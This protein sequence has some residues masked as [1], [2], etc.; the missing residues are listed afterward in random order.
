ME[1]ASLKP[2]YL[3]SLM[4]QDYNYSSVKTP[5]GLTARTLDDASD[6]FDNQFIRANDGVLV[7]VGDLSA[8]SVQKILCQY[9]GGFRVSK[10]S[11]VRQF[12][13]YKLRTGATTYSRIGAPVEI[14]LALACAEP[15]TT[16]NYMAFKV[17]S[18]ALQRRLTGV[19]AE[20]GF[21][22]RMADRFS[23]WPQEA[24]E[25]IFTCTPVPESGLPYGVKSGSDQPMRTLV[26]ARKVIENV[27]SNPVNAA[28]LASCKS[29]LTNGYSTYLADPKNY[30][31]A[32]LM[33]YSGGKDVL[34]GYNNRIGS[35]SADKVKE[36]FG[37]LSEGMRIE[38]VVKQ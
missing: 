3:D 12:S 21:S 2:A 16:E 38:Y 33:R 31:D 23:I 32:V 10:S 5:S 17:A 36:I 11:S 9:L 27:L 8:E 24:L 28:E 37:A 6:F 34:T 20:H 4:Y 19:M 26:E 1:L 15:F 13:S 7:I 25:L 18:L 30:V 35:V 29:L 22:V 14:S